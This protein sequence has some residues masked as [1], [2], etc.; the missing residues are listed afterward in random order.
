MHNGLK[1]YRNSLVHGKKSFSE[2]GRDITYNE[3]DDVLGLEDYKKFTIEHLT[4]FLN[5]VE[6]YIESEKYKI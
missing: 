6:E 3:L 5:S 2:I 4:H 1:E